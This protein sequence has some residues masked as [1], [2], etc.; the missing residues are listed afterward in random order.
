VKIFVFNNR[1][2]SSIRSTQTAF[3]EGR[4]V[5]SDPSSGVGNPDFEKLAAAY[6]IR[7]E[8]IRKNE[9]LRDGLAAALTGDDPVLCE[10]NIAVS[11]WVSPKASAFRRADG[12]LE[13][14]PLQDMAPFLPREEVWENM[15]LFDGDEV[16][17][18]SPEERSRS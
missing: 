3:A 13:S 2:Y 4:F 1:G 14:R 9:G 16:A 5:G 12:T 17:V 10:V 8:A 18:T 6:G 15:H 11:Q 7:Y